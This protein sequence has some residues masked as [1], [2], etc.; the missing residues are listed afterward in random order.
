MKNSDKR[1][2]YVLFL[3]IM[4]WGYQ[5]SLL[6]F[7]IPIAVILEARF[8]TSRRWELTMSDFYRT[9]DLTSFIFIIVSFYLFLNRANQPFLT[10][11][12]AWLPIVFFPLVTVMAYSTKNKMSLDILF[13]SLRRQ[14][15]PINQAWNMNFVYLGMC[16]VASATQVPA[17]LGETSPRVFFFP[18]ATTLVM[19]AL[20]PTR[21]PR[22][23]VKIW[24]LSM[25]VIFLVANF[26]HQG[27][28]STHLAFKDWTQQLIANYIQQ[29]SDP[30]RTKTSMGAVG[31]LKR[32]DAILFRVKPTT[33]HAAPKLLQEASYDTPTANGW[34]VI[35]TDFDDVSQT[36]DFQWSFG[37]PQHPLSSATIYQTFRRDTALV[38][39]PQNLARISDLPATSVSKSQYGTVKGQGLVPSPSFKLS[40]GGTATVAT[41][42]TRVDTYIPPE[43]SA[44]MTK[45]LAPHIVDGD[46]ILTLQ[47]VFKNF[48]YSLYQPATQRDVLEEFLVR[49]KA[50]HCEYFASA[51]VLMLRELG[52]P[53][54][55]TVG[56]AIQEYE[57]ML[58]MFIV[59]QRHA[60][61]WAQAFIDGKW[62]VIDMTPSIWADNEAAE[63]SFLRP[64]ID[65]LSNATFAFQIWWNSQKIEDYETALSILGAILVSFLLWRIFTSKQVLIKDDEHCQQRGLRQ[66]GAQSPFYRIEECLTRAGLSRLT[67]ETLLNWGQRVD[68][69][70][71]TPIVESHNRWR[72][73]PEYFSIQEQQNLEQAVDR[74]FAQ[75]AHKFSSDI[76]TKVDAQNSS[77]LHDSAQR[78]PFKHNTNV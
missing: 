48:R 53:A 44:L 70:E 35:N 65:L 16:L 45:V 8:F 64:A 11:L 24:L 1:L 60:H 71:L 23:S 62:Q 49:S 75:H 7:A 6:A 38:P 3:G 40:F 27:L 22:F 46:P 66:P 34:M 5:C 21:S 51:T 20:F 52:I 14:P 63:A 78:Q 26:T 9:A 59:R 37:N 17:S 19:L 55:Y 31:R 33:G 72:F 50:G 41:K 30:L 32:S 15:E 57:P 47:S 58:D 29:R 77:E 25:G 42:A 12:I 43:Q 76:L 74:W 4:F 18:I 39:V 56:F 68:L 2:R 54:R 28:R 13:Y 10:T 69:P 61:A 36:D 73:D 67:G